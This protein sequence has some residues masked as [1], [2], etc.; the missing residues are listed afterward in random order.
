MGASWLLLLGTGSDRLPVAHEVPLMAFLVHNWSP[1]GVN[2]LDPPT[3]TLCVE[4]SFYALLPLIGM[5]MIKLGPK[6]WRL[7]SLCGVLVAISLVW[8]AWVDRTGGNGQLH[9]VLPSVVYACAFGLIVALV[10]ERRAQRGAP[11]PS[12]ANAWTLVAIGLVLIALNAVLLVP[13][14][15]PGVAVYRDLPGAIGF[16]FIV[17][18]T[19]RGALQ[20]F[21]R[22]VP[23]WLG[24]R[25]Y[26]IYL[27]H[28]P[29]I[30]MLWS[31]QELP[32]H[33]WPALGMVV[34]LSVLLA[35][36]SWRF[37]ERPAID[38]ARR[39]TT[40]SK[41]EQGTP[42]QAPVRGRRRLAGQGASA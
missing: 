34:T 3:W 18:G 42:E 36:A 23:R 27:W 6:P 38:W 39:R 2:R 4:A 35:A 40:R 14:N 12:R 33:F 5:L 15:A 16:A 11:A 37:V 25:S 17:L 9:S 28:F 30:L 13:F 22:G 32:K 7:I 10:S 21:G 24:E 29:M 31:R 19:S 41:P 20:S 1:T 8:N 26:G